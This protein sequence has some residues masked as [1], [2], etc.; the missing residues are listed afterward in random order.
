VQKQNEELRT[1]VEVSMENMETNFEFA[2]RLKS[3]DKVE[4]EHSVNLVDSLHSGKWF[5]FL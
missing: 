1:V 3:S 2:E 5:L 4:D